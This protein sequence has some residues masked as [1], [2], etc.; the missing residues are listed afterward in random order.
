MH[1]NQESTAE[2]QKYIDIG[3]QYIEAL[4]NQDTDKFEELFA[5]DYRESGPFKDSTYTK[6]EAINKWR[7]AFAETDTIIYDR[8]HTLHEEIEE[9][10][11]QGHWVMEWGS[12]K[13]KLS[14][15]PD[16][17]NADIHVVIRIENA[18]ITDV[19]HFYNVAEFYKQLGFSIEPP[20][21]N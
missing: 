16:T 10:Y 3:H 15:Y 1:Q 17:V 2:S 5:E 9:G 7:N 21:S 19:H 6:E 13:E 20:E 11:F 14:A 8:I 4:S 18:K 12:I